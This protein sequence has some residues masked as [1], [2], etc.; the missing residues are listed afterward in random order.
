[1]TDYR[2]HSTGSSGSHPGAAPGSSDE[3]IDP[4]LREGINNIM[5]V[6]STTSGLTSGFEV[7][8]PVSGNCGTSTTSWKSL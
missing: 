6:K 7:L 5:Y 2:Q 8:F 1:M 3:D 4:E